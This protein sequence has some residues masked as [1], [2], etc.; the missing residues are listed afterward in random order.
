MS[1]LDHLLTLL[2]DAS[3]VTALWREHDWFETV[4]A[5][6]VK[7]SVGAPDLGALEVVSRRFHEQLARPLP[8]LLV[9]FLTRC[10]GYDIRE[11]SGEPVHEVTAGGVD[12]HGLYGAAALEIETTMSG[13]DEY[14]GLRIG[15]VFNQWPILWMLDGPQGGSVVYPDRDSEVPLVLA[16]DLPS[17]FSRLADAGLSIERMIPFE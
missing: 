17:F 13:D 10:D 2:D 16:E 5:D 14:Y 9:E 6:A 3:A 8:P 7:I 15:R 11:T 4:G 12:S 1:P